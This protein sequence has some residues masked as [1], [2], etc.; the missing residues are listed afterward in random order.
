MK[1]AVC[2]ERL[3]LGGKCA[4]CGADY[5]EVNIELLE[6]VGRYEF[7]TA[8]MIARLVEGDPHTHGTRPCASCKAISSLL[9]RPF[10]CEKNRAGPRSTEM[11]TRRKP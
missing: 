2:Q 11:V 8:E 9:D 7:R 4:R 3:N 10:G 1:C 5:G 6:A